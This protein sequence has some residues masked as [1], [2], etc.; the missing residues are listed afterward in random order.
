MMGP[1]CFRALRRN[2]WQLSPMRRDPTT[3]KAHEAIVGLGS[4]CPSDVANRVFR[5]SVRVLQ[6][7]RHSKTRS[8]SYPPEAKSCSSRSDTCG[9][10]ALARRRTLSRVL[11]TSSCGTTRTP[12]L[13]RSGFGGTRRASLPAMRSQPRSTYRKPDTKLSRRLNLWPPIK[14]AINTIDGDLGVEIDERKLSEGPGI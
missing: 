7:Q 12:A 14:R 1:V 9:S 3:A 5:G 8:P 13:A 2:P 4:M 10:P 6:L 11:A